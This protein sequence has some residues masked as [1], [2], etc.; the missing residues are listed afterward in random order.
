ML[1]LVII[2]PADLFDVA[3]FCDPAPPME[4]KTDHARKANFGFAIKKMR[5]R[6][7]RVDDINLR[8]PKAGVY[9]R[10]V[11][12]KLELCEAKQSG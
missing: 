12:W 11:R 3:L 5:D 4:G 1:T 10:A 7:F 8:L 9:R 6:V 2:P